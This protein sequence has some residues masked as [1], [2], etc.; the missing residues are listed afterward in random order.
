VRPVEFPQ[1]PFRAVAGDGASGAFPGGDAHLAFLTAQGVAV[2]RIMRRAQAR[3]FAHHIPELPVGAQ[4]LARRETEPTLPGGD[5]HFLPLTVTD[6]RLRPFARRLEMTLRPPVVD[7]RSRKP[8]VLLRL[9]L[10]GW[11]VRFMVISLLPSTRL[12]SN[13]GK[14]T[15][16]CPADHRVNRFYGRPVLREAGKRAFA[17]HRPVVNQYFC[18]KKIVVRDRP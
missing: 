10:C 3:P 13:Y 15:I 16:Y 11:Y 2:Y 17:D 1:Q 6:R 9:R 5:G 4:A 12:C 14:R 18:G 8:W 7:I